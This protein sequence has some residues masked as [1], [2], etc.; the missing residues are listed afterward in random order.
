MVKETPSLG[1]IMA[2]VVF[3]L[4]CVGI[5]LFLWLAFGGSIPLRAGVATAF[6]VDVPGGAATLSPGGRCAHRRGERRQ[7]QE[8]GAR[9]GRRRA[10]RSR[11]RSSPTSRRSRKNT[12]AILRQKTLLGETYVELSPATRARPRSPGIQRGGGTGGTGSLQDGGTLSAAQV[13]PTVELDEIFNTFDKPT[14]DAFQSWVKELSVAIKGR[15]AGD[16]NARLGIWVRSRR[17]ADVA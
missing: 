11:S 3:T 6:E 5:L 8:E 16:L 2:M 10:P 1:R 17:R 15:G 12:R 9:H 7:G 13:E 4:S 14:R